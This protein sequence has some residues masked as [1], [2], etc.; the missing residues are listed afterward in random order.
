MCPEHFVGRIG[1]VVG[2]LCCGAT[3][4][5]S[6]LVKPRLQVLGP[7]G[8][9]HLLEGVTNTILKVEAKQEQTEAEL[10]E[11]NMEA[12]KQLAEKEKPAR[13][14]IAGVQR[15]LLKGYE[16]V[17]GDE[18]SRQETLFSLRAV[19]CFE[20]GLHQQTIEVCA[21]WLNHIGTGGHA[22]WAIVLTAY[23][24]LQLAEQPHKLRQVADDLVVLIKLLA[25][26]PDVQLASIALP[27]LPSDVK[28]YVSHVETVVS[29]VRAIADAWDSAISPQH[30]CHLKDVLPEGQVLHPLEGVQLRSDRLGVYSKPGPLGRCT[31]YPVQ[32][33][34]AGQSPCSSSLSIHF[35]CSAVIAGLAIVG[36]P[37][38][39]LGAINAARQLLDL[40]HF[41]LDHHPHMAHDY[42]A[43]AKVEDWTYQQSCYLP[44]MGTFMPGHHRDRRLSLEDYRLLC[45]NQLGVK[46]HGTRVNRMVKQTFTKWCD[47]FGRHAGL[48]M[49]QVAHLVE[50]AVQAQVVLMTENRRDIHRDAKA[51]PDFGSVVY[52][53]TQQALAFIPPADPLPAPAAAS[54][55]AA[56]ASGTG[57]SFASGAFQSESTPS[58]SAPPNRPFTRQGTSGT[59]PRA[60]PQNRGF[61]RPFSRSGTAGPSEDTSE[62]ASSN[63]ANKW[64][65]AQGESSGSAQTQ[66]RTQAETPAAAAATKSSS[67]GSPFTF[68]WTQGTAEGP[69]AAEAAMPGAPTGKPAGS[70]PA[71][72]T[73]GLFSATPMAGASAPTE[74]TTTAPTPKEAFKWSGAFASGTFTPNPQSQSQ[75]PAAAQPGAFGSFSTPKPFGTSSGGPA[76]ADAAAGPPPSAPRAA[77]AGTGNSAPTFPTVADWSPSPPPDT[78]KAPDTGSSTLRSQSPHPDTGKA[79]AF[80]T[81]GW[82]PA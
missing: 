45:N 69:P 18:P 30:G 72:G 39:S 51:G 5:A 15:T 44:R 4:E 20:T 40:T 37:S 6:A 75:S 2:K 1:Q 10:M 81:P 65:S 35:T 50:E 31:V 3:K 26:H 80:G 55:H 36:Q 82:S 22:V 11:L 24:Q 17:L 29:G 54:G 14:H 63:Q 23:A 78:G 66:P 73:P 7:L 34:L 71:F 43:R 25:E 59:T 49:P 67:G 47:A 16:R 42:I 68:S 61:R 38:N 52:G 13:A 27:G 28:G 77:A 19:G 58:G 60:H 74:G 12:L 21:E 56:G 8:I 46:A 64:S 41:A 79:P 62:T 57:T 9:V 33:F 48:E 32:A 70:S 76:V 53:S